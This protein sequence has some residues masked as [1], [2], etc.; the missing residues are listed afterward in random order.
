[1]KHDTILVE[2]LV[3][4]YAGRRFIDVETNARMRMDLALRVKISAINVDF[5]GIEQNIHTPARL[6]APLATTN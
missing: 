3:K 6:F 2:G 4:C 5:P 1:M